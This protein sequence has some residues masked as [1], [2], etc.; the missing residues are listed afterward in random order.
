MN[1]KLVLILA[2]LAILAGTTAIS[3][4]IDRGG[5]EKPMAVYSIDDFSEIVV[6]SSTI[7]DVQVIAPINKL[8]VTSFG[9]I[10]EYPTKDGKWIQ[11]RFYGADLTV[12]A[13][14]VVDTMWAQSN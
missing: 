1:R 14:E 4:F 10:A 9:G 8:Y 12:E 2:F 3:L 6:S 11:I 7:A 13:I 5:A